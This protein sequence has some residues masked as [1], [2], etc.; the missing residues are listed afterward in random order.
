[1]ICSALLCIVSCGSDDASELTGPFRVTPSAAEEISELPYDRESAMLTGA[2]VGGTPSYFKFSDGMEYYIYDNH[3][4]KTYRCELSL[5]DGFEDGNIIAICSG[6]GSGEVLIVVET[7]Y[8][9]ET[10]YL[11]YYF[12]VGN[13]M[14][15]PVEVNIHSEKSIPYPNS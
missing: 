2:P 4:K 5:P 14:S 7:A 8:G 9:D 3:T 15:E 10:V 6:A 13:S 1:L 11:D 12:Y